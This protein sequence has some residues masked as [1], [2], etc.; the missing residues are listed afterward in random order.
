MHINTGGPAFPVP[1]PTL[2]ETPNDGW[3]T[4]YAEPG[5]TMR[6][7]FAAKAL[8]GLLA[9][10]RGRQDREAMANASYEYADAMIA[11]SLKK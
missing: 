8:Q 10:A 9:G 5:I 6:D 3:Q 11:E 2:V 7:Y 4:Y 1:A